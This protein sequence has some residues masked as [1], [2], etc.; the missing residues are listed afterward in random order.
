MDKKHR[1]N[2]TT[3]RKMK[4]DGEKIV[5]LTAYDATTGRLAGAVAD[6]LLVGDSLANT[7][8]GYKNTLPVTMEEMLHHVKAVRRGAPDAFV[9]ADMPF[10]SYQISLERAVENAGRMI[11]EGGADAVKL[12][13]GADFAPLTAQLVKYGIPVMAHIGLLPQ[14]IMTSGVYK[15][16]GRGEAE[17]EELLKS[18]KEL[19]DAGAFSIVME[20]M[21]AALGEKISRALEVP[22]IGIGSGAG[23]DGQIQVL[24]DVLGLFEEFTPRHSKHYAELGKTIREALTQYRTEVK[25]G[26]FPG[27]ENCF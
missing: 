16:T 8:L 10:M 1:V 3:F 26:V 18:A 25:G 2:V 5:M 22:T 7:V 24:N 27:P 11:K 9:V 12:E 6:A 21:P 23:C 13:G 15:I 19:E 4:A 14:R 20:C 17:A